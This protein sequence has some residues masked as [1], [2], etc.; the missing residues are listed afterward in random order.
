MLE[1]FALVL[2]RAGARVPHRP[3]QVQL[4]EF[5]QGAQARQIR[6]VDVAADKVENL[7]AEILLWKVR[8]A[9]GPD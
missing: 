1:V 9:V 4:L 6:R 8:D 7:Q 5:A 3:R 2:V